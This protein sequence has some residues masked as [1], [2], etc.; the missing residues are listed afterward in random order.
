[1]DVDQRYGKM[2]YGSGGI[3]PR[4]T[5]ENLGLARTYKLTKNPL[6]TATYSWNFDLYLRKTTLPR[7]GLM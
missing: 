1:M 4:W 7:N 5:V 3:A 2:D 6:T